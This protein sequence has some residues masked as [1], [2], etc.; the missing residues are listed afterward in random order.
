M[1]E[2]EARRG[3]AWRFLRTVV[4]DQR[5]GV[6]GAVVSG[7]LWQVGAVGA[8]LVVK[9]AI[10]HGIVHEDRHTLL[11]WLGALVAVGL[12]EVGAGGFRHIYAIRN[13]SASDARVRDAIFAHALRLDAAYH[14]R[15]GPGELLSRA[16]SDSTHVARMMDAIGHTIGYALTVVAVATVMLVLDWQLALI[17]LI[18]VPLIT[19][20]AW[21]YSRKYEIGTRR[22]Q[23]A[24]ADTSTLVEEAVSGIRVVKGLG[25]GTALSGRFRSR[26]DKVVGRALDLARLDAVFNPLLEMLPILGIAAVLWIGGRQAISG[27]LSTG[28]FVAFNAYVVMLVWPLRVLGQRVTTV[29]KAVAAS[30]RITEVLE[31]EPRLQE[32]RHP[33][34][35]EQPVRGDVRLEDVHFGHQGDQPVLDG[36]DLHLAP[37]E[38]L[39]LAGATGSGK[40]TVAGLLA[41]LYD[42]EGGR[43]LLDGHDLRDLRI[44]DVR[45]AVALVFEETFLFSESVRENI[46]FGRPDADDSD[47]ERAARLAGAT[48]FVADLPDGYDTILGERG[49]SLSGGQRQ[50]IAIARAILADPAV[51]VLDDATSAVDASK[52]HEIRAA[53]GEVMRGRTTLVIAHRPAT[54]ALA[55]RV[56]VLEGGRIV[57]EATHAELLRTSARYRT[58]LALEEAA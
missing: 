54:I 36:L 55:D 27:N 24:W 10:D 1:G 34:I 40:S 20:A 47:V 7:L 21:L 38:S 35:L 32:P 8:P 31:A 2:V 23:E 29:Q 49:F 9:Y 22:L 46:R 53:L 42:P 18:P 5:A 16:S 14:D 33:E 45:S 3:A 56:A 44:S 37:G 4:R 11:I 52:E 57:E 17:V 41:R 58:L 12:L 48:E 6:I 25:A 19:V 50:R 30:A 51:L 26:S 13:R 39:A 15:V 43:V 28:T